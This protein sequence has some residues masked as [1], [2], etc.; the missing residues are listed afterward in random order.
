MYLLQG[1][2]PRYMVNP[3][4]RNRLRREAL[5]EDVTIR[6]KECLRITD[7]GR[8]AVKTRPSAPGTKGEAAVRAS[9]TGKKEP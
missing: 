1:A 3:G 4:V 5:V 2:M 8:E 7:A 9:R 6:G